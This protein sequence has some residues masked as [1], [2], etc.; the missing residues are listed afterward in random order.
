MSIGVVLVCAGRGVRL[1]QGKAKAFVKVAG[2]PLYRW[3]LDLFS[4]I[5]SI[6]HIVVVADKAYHPLIRRCKCGKPLSL[7][8][9]GSRRQDSVY[10]GVRALP[11]S[12]DKVIVHDGARPL[13]NE[14]TVKKLIKALSGYDSVTCGL[15]V[16]EALKKEK[17]G[18]I[19]ETMRREHVWSIQTPQAF[20]RK[21]LLQAYAE[22]RRNTVYDETQLMELAGVKT[23]LIEGDPL[24][25]KITYPDDLKMAE[26]LLCRSRG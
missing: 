16:K 23:K 6:N 15:P 1:K 18:F 25:I 8:Q 2:Q 21:K 19:R 11:E 5:R 14:K 24:N 13:L 7:S 12:I 22:F 20:D 3:S 17:R 26:L 10:N 9:G 4:R